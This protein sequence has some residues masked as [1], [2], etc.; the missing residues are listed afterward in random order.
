MS[1]GKQTP[2]HLNKESRRIRWQV[3][4]DRSAGYILSAP[5]II[6]ML[7]LMLYPLLHAFYLSFLDWGPN[8]STWLGLAN[9]QRLFSDSLFWK[10]LYN[11]LFYTVINLTV[12]MAL[13]LGFALLMNRPNP[14]TTAFRAIV[15][16]PVIIS[17]PVAAMAWIWVLDPSY[18][19]LNQALQ[20]LGVVDNPIPWLN[21]PIYSKWSIVL[22]NI[23]KG[24]GLSALLILAGLQN[25]PKELHEAATLDGA[26]AFR[27][28]MSITLPLLRPVLLVVLV[29]K[30]IGSFSTFDQV[31]I[32][33]GG[34][35]LHSSETILMYLY[36]SGFGL[37]DF[38]YASAVGMV[39]FVIVATLSILQVVFLRDRG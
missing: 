2:K 26:G 27:R 32:M 13:S 25:I 19:L 30:G 24:T 29:I 35:P 38:G 39:F 4:L 23:W 33:T 12:G 34:G 10:S 17:M 22:V 31:F 36:N 18:G 15:F 3:W 14:L 11:T 16:L 8:R 1:L 7:G 5:A 6:V 9:Y 28:L 21:S 20:S 37:F